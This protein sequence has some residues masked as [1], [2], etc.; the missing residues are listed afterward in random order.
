MAFFSKD[1]GIDLGTASILV[2]VK[3]K[4][5]V[6]HEPSVVALDERTHSIIAV[7]GD[8]LRM[9]GPHPRRGARGAPLA[10]RGHLRL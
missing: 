6:L 1:I 8:A 3:G 7:G 2:Y 10:R 5:I 4:G 9:M